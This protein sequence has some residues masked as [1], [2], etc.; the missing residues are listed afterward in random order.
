MFFFYIVVLVFKRNDLSKDN[1]I[2]SRF[3]ALHRGPSF[4]LGQSTCNTE[5]LHCGLEAHWNILKR[6]E[7]SWKPV[8]TNLL[9]VNKKIYFR[10]LGFHRFF[11][12]FFVQGQSASWWNLRILGDAWGWEPWS[13][14]KVIK[15]LM[16]SKRD[17]LFQEDGTSPGLQN[18]GCIWYLKCICW[19]LGFSSLWSRGRVGWMDGI[20]GIDGS[21]R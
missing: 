4:A 9:C 13:S 14:M 7:I 6:L 16:A 10:F 5:G 17:D 1:E 19:G 12:V 2:F 18:L 3:G 11:R 21:I 20:D 15:C 8:E